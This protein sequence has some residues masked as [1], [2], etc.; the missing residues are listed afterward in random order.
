MPLLSP[1]EGKSWAMTLRRLR[2]KYKDDMIRFAC[3]DILGQLEDVPNVLPPKM[4]LIILNNGVC[5]VSVHVSGAD[6]KFPH[7]LPG[8]NLSLPNA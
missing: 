5:C 2:R 4:L 1:L 7:G 3:L 6:C 8:K